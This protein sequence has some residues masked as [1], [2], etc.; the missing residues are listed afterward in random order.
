MI[1]D[2]ASFAVG[3]ALGRRKGGGGGGGYR[4]STFHYIL[5]NYIPVYTYTINNTYTLKI[6]LCM[7]Y[8]GNY[9]KGKP[10]V[11]DGNVVNAMGAEYDSR[12]D[13]RMYIIRPTSQVIMVLVMYKNSV[14]IYATYERSLNI[15]SENWAKWDTDRFSSAFFYKQQSD[16]SL[17]SA[18]LVSCSYFDLDEPYYSGSLEFDTDL[19]F[20]CTTSYQKYHTQTSDNPLSVWVEKD[21]DRIVNTSSSLSVSYVN[22]VSSYNNF[23]DMSTGDFWDEIQNIYYEA[24]VAEGYSAVPMVIKYPID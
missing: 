24:C 22:L 7:M 15:F 19:T 13:R 5:D 2:I 10:P 16:F 17:D 23:T 6:G 18:L 4:D 20:S 21:G 1:M 11:M 12:T 14:P 9:I 8:D 3:F